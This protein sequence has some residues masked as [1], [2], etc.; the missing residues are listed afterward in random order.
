MDDGRSRTRGEARAAVGELA[1]CDEAEAGS[2]SCTLERST[3][4]YM[5]CTK[6]LTDERDEAAAALETR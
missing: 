4:A 3:L 5:V 1:V 2:N 6:E